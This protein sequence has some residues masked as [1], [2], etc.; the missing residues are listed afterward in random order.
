MTIAPP[1]LATVLR[2]VVDQT[3]TPLLSTA[4]A[5]PT[6]VCSRWRPHSG[7]TVSDEDDPAFRGDVA[8]T[9]GARNRPRRE[10]RQ[11]WSRCATGAASHADAWVS[12]DARQLAARQDGHSRRR[13]ELGRLIAA[14]GR[15]GAVFV[16][17]RAS[18]SRSATCRLRARRCSTS[19][20]SR[21]LPNTSGD[22]MIITVDPGTG[23]SHAATMMCDFSAGYTCINASIEHERT[24]KHPGGIQNTWPSRAGICPRSD[25]SPEEQRVLNPPRR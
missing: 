7:V 13:S 22:R 24:R 3:S 20:A 4:S 23:G 17:D 12:A 14:A 25:L 19:G 2:R 16:L 18:K 21:P 1:L 8:G 11:S 15:S 9:P 6:T 5:R 10:A